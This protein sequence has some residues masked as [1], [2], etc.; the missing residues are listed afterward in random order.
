MQ[1]LITTLNNAA[2]CLSSLNVA[3]SGTASTNSKHASITNPPDLTGYDGWTKSG[4][5]SYQTDDSN[6]SIALGTNNPKYQIYLY[7]PTYTKPLLVIN[8]GSRSWPYGGASRSIGQALL[9]M[10]EDCIE[11]HGTSFV[12]HWCHSALQDQKERTR[13]A[14]SRTGFIGHG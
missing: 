4:S 6:G 2:T 9:G 5:N 7:T 12:G 3:G 10:G 1:Y 8:A 11:K 13:E 14:S